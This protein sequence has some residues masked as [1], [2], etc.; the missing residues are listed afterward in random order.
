M[1]FTDAT[2]L[3]GVNMFN[4]QPSFVNSLLAAQYPREFEVYMVA[5]E[6]TTYNDKP[7]RYLTF[8][9]NPQSITKSEPSLKSIKKTLGGVTI[10]KSSDFI[11]QDLTIKGNFGRNWKILTDFSK[12]TQTEFTAIE[13]KRPNT[14]LSSSVNEEEVLVSWIKSGYGVNKVLQDIIHES[15]GIDKERTRKLYFHNFPFGESYLIEVK[16]IQWDQTLQN[17]M[18]WGYTLSA[19]IVA[20][21]N[22]SKKLDFRNITARSMSGLVQK[23]TNTSM[24]SI[25][26]IITDMY[27]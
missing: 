10:N 21:A 16:D 12:L 22:Q 24:N 3:L 11:P 6:L 4:E 8:P 17:N 7:L 9:V 1:N 2:Q 19:T 15:D 23:I 26:S 5:L 13:I 20:P 25:K 14:S 18:M 27:L